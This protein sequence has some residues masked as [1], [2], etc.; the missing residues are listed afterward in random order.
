MS[1]Y[2]IC[3]EQSLSIYD[4]PGS[5]YNKAWL[6]IQIRHCAFKI[7][8]LSENYL[9]NRGTQGQNALP[10]AIELT[11]KREDLWT[12]IQSVFISRVEIQRAAKTIVNHF[13]KS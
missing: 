12:S 5:Y 2:P 6:S 3:K 13:R 9:R 8:N 11:N 7:A 10:N 1:N 4:V